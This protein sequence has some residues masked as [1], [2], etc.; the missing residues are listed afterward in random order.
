MIDRPKPSYQKPSNKSLPLADPTRHSGSDIMSDEVLALVAATATIVTV[1]I[2][3]QKNRRRK[4]RLCV[5]PIFQRP[6]SIALKYYQ[7]G[8]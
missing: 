4:K 2:N 3:R 1:A 8:G 5:R 7:R 6:R